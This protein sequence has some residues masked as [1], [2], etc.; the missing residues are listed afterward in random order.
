MRM[1]PPNKDY[2]TLTDEPHP[3]QYVPVEGLDVE[4]VP[5]VGAGVE[6]NAGGVGERVDASVDEIQLLRRWRGNNRDEN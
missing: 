5:L 6:A 4:V 3:L 2:S 1:N